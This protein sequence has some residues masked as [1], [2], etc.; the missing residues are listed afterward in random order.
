MS[1]STIHDYYCGDYHTAHSG[2]A[3]P[4]I[5]RDAAQR[6]V[7]MCQE[8]FPGK[9]LVFLGWGGSGVSLATACLMEAN[10]LAKAR[11]VVTDC[12]DRYARMC[13]MHQRDVLIFVDDYICGGNTLHRVSK[14]AKQGGC[15]LSL[16][17]A[18]DVGGGQQEMANRNEVTIVGLK[19]GLE[20][21]YEPDEKGREG[22]GVRVRSEEKAVENLAQ[23]ETATGQSGKCQDDDKPDGTPQF[24]ALSFELGEL[25][26]G[27]MSNFL[28]QEA[29]AIGGKITMEVQGLKWPR[30]FLGE[31][32]GVKLD[33][34]PTD[35][36]ELLR[37][38]RS[39]VTGSPYPPAAPPTEAK[40][41]GDGSRTPFVGFPRQMLAARV[42]QRAGAT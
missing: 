40:S 1:E 15:R 12:E 37:S 3:N 20:T 38:G 21:K 22:S 19:D 29:M 33:D 36:A 41:R 16:A 2:Y 24:K 27:G 32:L 31:Y 13:S 8:R 35:A 28:R 30:Q 18:V 26:P 25:L 4:G 9:T 42:R 39:P 5:L 6:I 17:I 23:P 7:K 11:M 14:L 10:D 34:H